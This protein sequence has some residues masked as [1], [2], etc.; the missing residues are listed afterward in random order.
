M[1]EQENWE[2]LNQVLKSAT[3]VL[4]P[5]FFFHSE[6]RE[7]I[8]KLFKKIQNDYEKFTDGQCGYYKAHVEQEMHAQFQMALLILYSYA[9]KDKQILQPATF[10][11]SDTEL[12]VC[13]LL[14]K[15]YILENFTPLELHQKLLSGDRSVESFYTGY[16]GLRRSINQLVIHD[17]IRPAIRH[18]LKKQGDHYN[19]KFYEAFG[20]EPGHFIVSTSSAQQREF[21]FINRIEHK[22]KSNKDCIRFSGQCFTVDE[23]IKGDTFSNCSAT[24]NS[25]NDKKFKRT[26]TVPKNQYIKAVFTEKSI[27]LRKK[28]LIFYAVFVSHIED[29]LKNGFD[30]KPLE[31]KEIPAY[32]DLGIKESC[33]NFHH[34]LFCIAS[35]TGFEN[36]EDSNSDKKIMSSF[37]SSNVTL[38]FLDLH[39][40]KKFFNEFD[41]KSIELSKICDLETKGE[42]LLKLKKILYPEMDQK[43]LVSQSVSLKHCIEFSKT[44]EYLD[45]GLVEEIFSHYAKEKKLV[46]KD[47]PPMGPVIVL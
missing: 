17:E 27:T 29:Y 14:K 32:L 3:Q 2:C 43:L 1:T 12:E 28:S 16:A 31:L 15:F 13:D 23:I 26:D 11:F 25:M 6:S 35:P 33:K 10:S 20:S 36:I 47:I 34:I 21:D 41:K 7:R 22:L 39:K 8:D 19:E 5:A 38:C 44:N 46:I 9:K 40:N 4:N 30:S 37:I 24:S 18:Y 42:T 45:S